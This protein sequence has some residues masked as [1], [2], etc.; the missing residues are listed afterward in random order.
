MMPR[1]DPRFASRRVPEIHD[2]DYAF[3][4]LDAVVNPVR[5][6][7]ESADVVAFV[8]GPPKFRKIS[9]QTG[10]IHQTKSKLFGTDGLSCAI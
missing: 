6:A 5:L 1:S 8:I 4:V 7:P 3:V 10:A 2:F 9:K